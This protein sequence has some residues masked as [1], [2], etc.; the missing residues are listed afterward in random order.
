MRCLS[1][2]VRDSCEPLTGQLPMDAYPCVQ[3]SHSLIC[4]VILMVCFAECGRR[5]TVQGLG[6][7]D[8]L[9]VGFSVPISPSD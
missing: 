7:T 2:L 8:S 1:S 6:D 9:G 3:S 5:R 4:G